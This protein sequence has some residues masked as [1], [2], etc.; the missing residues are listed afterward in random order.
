VTD[1]ANCATPLVVAFP[2]AVTTEVE[3]QDPLLHRAVLDDEAPSRLRLAWV[4]A[5][6]Q[7]APECADAIDAVR[8]C[9]LDGE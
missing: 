2:E 5:L 6:L 9:G 3:G 7:H 4:R 1:L 8:C